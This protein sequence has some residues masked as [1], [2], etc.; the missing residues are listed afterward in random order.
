MG[1][2]KK[3]YIVLF[4]PSIPA[5]HYSILPWRKIEDGHKKHYIS[6]KL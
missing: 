2:I 1:I 5:F 6:N 4:I 3:C